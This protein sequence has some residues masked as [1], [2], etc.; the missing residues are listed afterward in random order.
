MVHHSSAWLRPT[1]HPFDADAFERLGDGLIAP[2]LASALMALPGLLGVRS[3]SAWPIAGSLILFGGIAAMVRATTQARWLA[4]VAA[5]ASVFAIA[6]RLL[7]DLFTL[8]A[9]IPLTGFGLLGLALALNPRS[10]TSR[11]R[12][13]ASGAFLGAAFLCKLWLATP[14]VLATAFV[15]WL[16]TAQRRII[17]LASFTAGLAAVSGAHL[18]LLALL[19]P[20]SLE[21]WLRE[22]YFAILGFGGIA[23]TK[24]SGVAAH[25]EWSHGPWYYPPA[26]A[27]ELGFAAILAAMAVWQNVI[28]KRRSARFALPRAALLGLFLGVALLSVPIVKEPLYVLSACAF[29]AALAARH[30]ILLAR[31]KH[32]NLLFA[33]VLV[34][35]AGVTALVERPTYT[36]NADEERYPD[37]WLAGDTTVF[38]NSSHRSPD[39]KHHNRP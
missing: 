8:E 13:I 6:P 22:V 7:L 1:Y 32:C 11:M 20:G 29:G 39:A 23:A 17:M 27:R 14:L 19:D 34:V 30:L 4:I 9:E 35:A 12:A 36:R 16:R 21:R 25:P 38:R 37:R 28:T 18:A 10:R 15:W 24:W 5:V 26:I 2:P 31:T 33:C 3:P